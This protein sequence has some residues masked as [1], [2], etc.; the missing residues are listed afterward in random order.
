M[1]QNV[2]LQVNNL[3]TYFTRKPP[4]FFMPQRYVYAVDGISFTVDREETVGLVG[5][6]GCGKTT[7][8]RSILG[9]E[10]ITG[11][12]VVFDGVDLAVASSAQ[13]KALKKRMQIVFQ[14]PY[15]SLNPRMTINQT[16]REPLLLHTITT[17]ALVDEQVNALLHRVGLDPAQRHR[18]PH[19]F[20][21]GQRQRVCIAR[22][23]AVNPD[24]IVLDEPVSALD[25]SIQA[26][27]L[28][29][30][31]DIQESMK[32]SYLFIAHDLA[33]VRHISHRIIVMYLGK[34]MEMADTDALFRTPLHP[35]TVALMS[36][37]PV[38]N[39]KEK[40]QRIVL[41]GDLPSPAS[42]PKGCPFNTRCYMAEK[43]CRTEKPEL[44]EV[45][46]GHFVACHFYKKVQQKNSISETN[47]VS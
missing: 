40:K 28:N 9:L 31:M 10:P 32:L 7:T 21:G 25:V 14:D 20:S 6:S 33:V 12:S 39:K 43:I 36:A 16:L 5:E 13:W 26:Q 45:E 35:Y 8:G 4:F 1:T 15:G 29:L 3:K 27:I 42:P 23:L 11:G 46:S 37:V 18:Y 17:R 19:E 30:L 44:T 24:F 2:L 41:H 34:I 47:R 38:I 22:A